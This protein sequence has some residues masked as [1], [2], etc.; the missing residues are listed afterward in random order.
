MT[1]LPIITTKLEKMIE[2]LNNTKKDAFL[3]S[4]MGGGCNGFNYNLKAVEKID[5]EKIIDKSSLHQCMKET[6]TN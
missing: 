4:A 5:I 3:F 6:T 1:R 2:V